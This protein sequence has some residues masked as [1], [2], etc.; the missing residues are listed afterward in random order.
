MERIRFLGT[1][2]DSLDIQ[3]ALDWRGTR[4]RERNPSTIAVVNANKFWLMSKDQRLKQFVQG[5]DLVVPEWA[6][7]WGAARLGTPLKSYVIG[8]AL[9]QAALPWAEKNGY[10]I[11]FLGAKPDVIIALAKS[12]ESDFPGLKIAGL[13]H[14]YLMTEDQHQTVCEEIRKS[15]PDIVFVAMGSPRQEYWMAENSR[16]LQ[17]PVCMGVGGTFDVLA[18]LKHDTPSWARGNGL[19]WVYRLSQEPGAYWERYLRCNAW[20]VYQVIRAR[21][22]PVKSRR[23]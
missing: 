21:L 20:F 2:V 23:G 16:S 11:Y 7:L 17:I 6:V 8:S 12:L 10:R 1:P 15:K 22:S 3:D 5:A 13:H 14:G 18:G 19:E 4:I 9:L